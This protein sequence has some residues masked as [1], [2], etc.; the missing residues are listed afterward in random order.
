LT[1]GVRVASHRRLGGVTGRV[2][3]AAGELVETTTLATL[4][5]LAAV[6]GR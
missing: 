1:L 2:V 3:L 6:L 4:A 5:A